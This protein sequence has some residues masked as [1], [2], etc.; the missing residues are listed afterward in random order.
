MRGN[1]NERVGIERLSLVKRMGKEEG[2]RC[3]KSG[4]G[5]KDASGD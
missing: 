2:S 3:E 4:G 1:Q 5:R